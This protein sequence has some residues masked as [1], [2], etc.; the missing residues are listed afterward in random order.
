[1]DD[2]HLDR[3]VAPNLFDAIVDPELVFSL[4]LANL[5]S[6]RLW[7]LRARV[8]VSADAATPTAQGM[9]PQVQQMID[10]HF[11]HVLP[12]QVAEMNGVL[13]LDAEAERL[14]SETI[15]YA[16]AEIRA[17]FSWRMQR[18]TFPK[19][20]F[21]FELVKQRKFPA[22]V[23]ATIDEARAY[24]RFL[25]GRKHKPLG[26]TCCLDE[27]AI[28][29]A[30]N[31]ILP[32]DLVEDIALIG[33]PAHYT[34]F[35][36]SKEGAWWFY[37]KHELH[38]PTSWGQL[39]ADTYGDDTQ[40]AFD[41]RLPRFDRIITISGSYIFA[42]GESS[43]T[44][45]RLAG[46]V[47]GIEAFLGFR[48]AQLDRAL[49]TPPHFLTA[50]DL[51]TT[52]NEIPVGAGAAEVHLRLR[53]AAFE[54]DHPSAWGALHAYRSLNVPDLRVYLCAARRSIRLAD[55]FGTLETIDDAF[56]A[57]ASINGGDSIFEDANRIAM[58]DETARFA[59][60]TDRDKALLLHVLIEH[61]LTPN[62]PARATLETLFTDAG[63][64]VRSAQFC[65]NTTQMSRVP[66]VAGQTLHRI[67]D[68]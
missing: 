5:M 14:G 17:A 55:T 10:H 57:V 42:S 30:L 36:W 58:P 3:A 50:S 47:A 43:M 22:Y 9:I 21:S 37:S 28:F 65:F 35:T 51:A 12:S 19:D 34:V 66:Q 61:V 15:D 23:Y 32:D 62:D 41:D 2:A 67:A 20:A 53:R 68:W 29:T 59:T 63:S 6:P 25:R 27:A 24:R 54:E 44:E 49:A 60:G 31:L 64:F 33:S 45:E 56:R 1:M 46:I 7:D 52:I 26:L 16:L 48:P 38:S 18:G 39:V 13:D 40:A 8:L 4:V 11:E